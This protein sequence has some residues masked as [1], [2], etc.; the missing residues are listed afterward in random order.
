MRV[1]Q[2]VRRVSRKRNPPEFDME[3][4]RN[5]TNLCISK[6]GN[7]KGLPPIALMTRM[8]FFET[9]LILR[10]KAMLRVLKER[11]YVYRNKM[12]RLEK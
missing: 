1:L 7:D 3:E 9:G 4:A 5:L 8:L 2:E 10:D 11:G 6:Y 12:W